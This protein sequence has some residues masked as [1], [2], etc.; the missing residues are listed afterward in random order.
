MH[1][2]HVLAASLVI[3]VSVTAA[4]PKK[5]VLRHAVAV[6]PTRVVL[7][8]QKETTELRMKAK[9]ETI[10]N[11]AGNATTGF[12]WMVIK[13]GDGAV[14]SVGDPVYEKGKNRLASTGVGGSFAI[15][16]TAVAKGT[17]KVYLEYRRP[18]EKEVPP[19]KRM[20]IDITVE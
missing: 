16:L 7:D 12:S 4:E 6:L 13:P 1:F 20:T 2:M 17:T 8:D 10:V 18:W 9:S 14:V 5:P 11:L 3:A 19:T 15:K